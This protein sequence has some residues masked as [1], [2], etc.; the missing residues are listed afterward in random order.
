MDGNWE[1][2]A[3]QCD[4]FLPTLGQ[5]QG[6]LQQNGFINDPSYVPVYYT[7][8]PGGTSFQDVTTWIASYMAFY[9]T[10]QGARPKGWYWFW[11]A[12]N[13]DWYV[14]ILA[15]SVLWQLTLDRYNVQRQYITDNFAQLKNVNLEGDSLTA[16]TANEV[17]TVCLCEALAVSCLA[18]TGEYSQ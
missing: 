17:L 10:Q 5:C 1:Y 12:L 8:W 18:P 11:S 7:G 9:V 6:N 4:E 13:N 16:D 15:R 3:E 14:C 2:D